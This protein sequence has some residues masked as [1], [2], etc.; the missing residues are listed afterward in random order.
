LRSAITCA[1]HVAV[2]D[3][4]E[5]FGRRLVDRPTG[6]QVAIARRRVEQT[7]DFVELRAR[8]ALRGGL[9]AGVNDELRRGRGLHVAAE[10][11]DA[12]ERGLRQIGPHVELRHV[13]GVTSE[14]RKPAAQPDRKAPVDA[15]SRIGG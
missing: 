3:V 10:I 1:G 11:R 12:G 4:I 14:R 9:A 6:E 5:R 15:E 8:G 2:Q 13:V 7:Q